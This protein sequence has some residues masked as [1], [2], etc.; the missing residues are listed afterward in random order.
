MSASAAAGG[1]RCEIDASDVAS[2][3]H[4]ERNGRGGCV[5]VEGSSK[6][7]LSIS[8]TLHARCALNA[9]DAE[10]CI[11]CLS[12]AIVAVFLHPYVATRLPAIV[13][14]SGQ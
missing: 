13:C 4:S 3:M 1:G 6:I 14:A 5:H 7:S 10:V 12:G 8:T 2:N 11:S 9:I